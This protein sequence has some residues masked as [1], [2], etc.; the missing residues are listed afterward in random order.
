MEQPR[1]T[2]LYLKEI[3][4]FSSLYL[5][6]KLIMENNIVHFKAINHVL[7]CVTHVNCFSQLINF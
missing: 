2:N 4:I 7:K 3:N 5:Y 6:L 1:K